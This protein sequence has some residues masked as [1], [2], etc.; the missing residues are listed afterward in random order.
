MPT[1]LVRNITTYPITLPLPY[2]GILPA[3][4]AVPI[5]DTEANIVANLGGN[6]VV[7]KLFTLTQVPTAQGTSELADPV[8]FKARVAAIAPRVARIE[9]FGTVPAEGNISI[10]DLLP[11][12]NGREILRLG[13]LGLHGLVSYLIEIDDLGGAPTAHASV[14]IKGDSAPG[15]GVTVQKTGRDY[16]IH[17]EAGVSREGDFI[18]ALSGSGTSLRAYQNGTTFTPPG[19]VLLAGAGPA[20]DELAK[21]HLAGGINA[22]AGHEFPLTLQPQ[23]PGSLEVVFDVGWDGGDVTVVGFDQF[24]QPQTEVFTSPG[25]PGGTVH[26]TKVWKTVT[27]VTKAN[28]GWADVNAQVLND[29]GL[30]LSE[31]PESGATIVFVNAVGELPASV[32]TATGLVKTTTAPDGAKKFQVLFSVPTA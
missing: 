11:A 27:Q 3:G 16:V 20:G 6:A 9:D 2:N 18:I 5:V 29:V 4:E 15:A 8:G 7:S 31:K 23:I 30:G 17:F 22:P 24:D 14:T 13:L 1:F 21:T 12:T 10:T 25:A 32:S 19:A 28:F 26:G